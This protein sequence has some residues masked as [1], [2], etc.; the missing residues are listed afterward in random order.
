MHSGYK[1]PYVFRLGGRMRDMC[2]V[3]VAQNCDDHKVGY[4]PTALV[5]DFFPF[6]VIFNILRWL[7]MLTVNVSSGVAHSHGGI[8][9]RF[10]SVMFSWYANVDRCSTA[11]W[12]M[13]S[14]C[15][16][17]SPWTSVSREEG[18]LDAY[19]ASFGLPASL[20]C[21]Y[22]GG[23]EVSTE[24]YVQCCAWWIMPQIPMLCIFLVWSCNNA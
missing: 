17:C 16:L 1:G 2:T 6:N 12:W 11:G 22:I 5:L 3:A 18:R 9:I 4:I 8:A 20:L 14:L 10:S 21:P 15:S 13:V 7:I 23:E 19:K 24:L